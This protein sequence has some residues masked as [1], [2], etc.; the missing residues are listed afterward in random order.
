M[1]C[2][3]WYHLYR[4]K[5]LEFVKFEKHPG[6]SVTITHVFTFFKLYKWYQIAQSASYL[7]HE[8]DKAPFCG[9]LLTVLIHLIS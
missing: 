5:N 7:F 2:A 6:K 4:L 3:I 8:S 9:V 1:L